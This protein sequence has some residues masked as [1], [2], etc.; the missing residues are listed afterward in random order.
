MLVWLVHGCVLLA[1][2]TDVLVQFS[3]S[4]L[5]AAT[6]AALLR[7]VSVANYFTT[8]LLQFRVTARPLSNTVSS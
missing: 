5:A 7:E 1:G 3:L 6:A 4:S 2:S 8:V